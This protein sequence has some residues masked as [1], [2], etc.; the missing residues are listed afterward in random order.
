MGVF[1]TLEENALNA[2]QQQLLIDEA[3]GEMTVEEEGGGG[4]Q[5]EFEQIDEEIMLN[6]SKGSIIEQQ[7]HEVI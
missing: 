6:Q 1:E 5:D 3:V 4:G 2:Q 7:E